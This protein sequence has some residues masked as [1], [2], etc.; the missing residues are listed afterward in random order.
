MSTTTFPRALAAALRARQG[1]L[2]HCETLADAIDEAC[3]ASEPAAVDWC[4]ACGGTG[5]V[6][7]TSDGQ[8]GHPLVE[9]ASSAPDDEDTRDWRGHCPKCGRYPEGD[10]ECAEH[11][12]DDDRQRRREC[13]AAAKKEEPK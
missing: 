9:P 8:Q 10:H 1:C 11:V 13:E 6:P 4:N 12:F 3:E 5:R 7:G 2:L